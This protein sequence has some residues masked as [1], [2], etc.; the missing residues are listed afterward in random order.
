MKNRQEKM[1]PVRTLEAVVKAPGDRPRVTVIAGTR[2]AFE[3]IVG[4]CVKTVGFMNHNVI[5]C[6][7]DAQTCGMPENAQGICGTILVLG[8]GW[9]DGQFC[10]VVGPKY[11]VNLLRD[12]ISDISEAKQRHTA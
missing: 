4:G 7:E 5:L 1:R 6:N 3:S 8:R 9:E 10:D 2:E 11:V 12:D